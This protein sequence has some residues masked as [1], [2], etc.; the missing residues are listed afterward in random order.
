MTGVQAVCFDL[1]NTL[2]VRDHDGAVI[3]DAIF[4]RV[5]VEPFF[6]PADVHA[7]DPAD[8]PPA[9]TDRAFYEHLYRAVA[10]DVGGDPSHAPELA[11]ATVE[12]LDDDVTF[13]EGARAALDYARDRFDVGLLTQGLRDDQTAKLDQL[14]IRDAFDTIVFCGPGTG[15]APKPE[16]EPFQQALEGLDAAPEAAIYVGDSLG[17]DV[18]GAHAVGMQS[19]W[20]EGENPPE[21]PDPEPTYRLDSMAALPA[22]LDGL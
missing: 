1:D 21:V 20:I 3:H 14:G 6:G 16:P 9:E 18:A 2:C 12:V 19:V 8:L 11:R 22:V 15:V 5:D 7:V 17:G 13:R 4:A 10:D